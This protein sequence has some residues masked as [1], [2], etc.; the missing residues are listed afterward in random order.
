MTRREATRHCRRQ[1]PAT[2]LGSLMPPAAKQ[3]LGRPRLVTCLQSGYRRADFFADLG[4]GVT[5]GVVALP[6]AMAFAIASG[7][8][9]QAGIY[10]AIIA[11]FLISALG[12]SRVQIGGPTGAYIVVVY[13]IVSRYGVANLVICTLGAGVILCGDGRAAARRPDPLH[14]GQH[15]HRLHQRHRR[16]DPALAGPVLPR[17]RA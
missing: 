13:G 3:V 9:P 2:N 7:V 1:R 10:T 15:R 11:G 6:L 17:A 5:V 8:P 16:A 4:A 14:S 12:G